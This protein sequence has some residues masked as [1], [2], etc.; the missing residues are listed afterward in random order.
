MLT[1]RTSDGELK[2]DNDL[3]YPQVALILTRANIVM[4]SIHVHIVF[5]LYIVVFNRRLKS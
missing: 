2:L 3:R 4:L 1:S 5:F